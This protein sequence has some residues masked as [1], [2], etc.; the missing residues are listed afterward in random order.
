VAHEIATSLWL[1]QRCSSVLLTLHVSLVPERGGAIEWSLLIWDARDQILAIL[2]CGTANKN[3][4]SQTN[5]RKSPIEQTKWKLQRTSNCPY[6]L[7]RTISTRKSSNLALFG[8]TQVQK[9]ETT[10]M[11]RTRACFYLRTLKHIRFI[12][13]V[14]FG[15]SNHACVG[16]LPAIRALATTRARIAGNDR[17]RLL[18][19]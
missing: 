2:M 1:N 16:R 17:K 10:Q 4:S 7:I 9:E 12:I 15:A 13:D 19:S 6:N 3:T 14:P 8:G 11:K 5:G 18:R